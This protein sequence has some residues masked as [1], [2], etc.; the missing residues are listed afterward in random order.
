MTEFP[1]LKAPK[2]KSSERQRQKQETGHGGNWRRMG[3]WEVG[4]SRYIEYGVVSTDIQTVHY[5][6]GTTCKD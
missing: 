1:S 2:R 4:M 3:S 5:L 6:Q